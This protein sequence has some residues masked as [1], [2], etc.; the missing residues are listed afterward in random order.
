MV[1]S[2]GSATVL[3]TPGRRQAV[4]WGGWLRRQVVRLHMARL[5][6]I[7]RNGR[8]RPNRVGLTLVC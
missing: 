3:G 2:A 6:P 1:P 5:C 8:G 4:L 7:A